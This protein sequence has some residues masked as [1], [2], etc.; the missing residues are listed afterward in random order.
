MM[1]RRLHSIQA[2]MPCIAFMFFI[3][4]PARAS[5]DLTIPKF[6]DETAS[7]GISAIYKGD[8]QYMVGGGVGAFDCNG[9]GYPDLAFAGGE[10][11]AS[12]FINHSQ[13]NGELKF[14]KSESGIE[15]D[16]VTGVY[17][18]DLDGDTI[19]DLIL[20]RVGEAVLMRGEGQCK[21]RS[22]NEEWHFD[23]GNAWW[24][25][26]S[27]MW[28]KG[29]T[30]PT[31][32]LGAYI[33]PKFEFEPW[34]HCGDNQLYRPLPAGNYAAPVAL[35]PSYCTLSM[36]F[37]DWNNS[38]VPSLRVSNDR[39]YY[40]GGQEQMWH[41]DSGQAPRLYT[42][43]E[44]WKFLKIWGMGIASTYLS[45]DIYPSYFLTSMSDNKLQ[46]LRN[47]KADPPK[48]DYKDVAFDFGAVAYRPYAGDDLRPSTGW[49]SEFGD[50]NN[51]GL[52]DLF[53][54]KGNVDRMPDFAEKDP[55]NLMLQK[56]DRKFQE[57]G[58]K[59]GIL[60]FSPARGG[61]LVDLNLDGKLDLVVTHRR[62]NAKVWRNISQ[63][64][65]HYIALR[66]IGADGNRDGIGAKIEIRADGRIQ[67]REIAS[68]GGH[69][70]G[71]NGFW[72]FGL[73]DATEA[74]VRIIW[75]DGATSEWRTLSAD[76]FYR[77]GR[78]GSAVEFKP[79]DRAN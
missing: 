70:G 57:V 5:D 71:Q 37:T 11:L 10:G 15:F 24:T 61:A 29:N 69:A 17:P 41:L 60:N 13:R 34:G 63:S 16:K 68:G 42:E 79:A 21:F 22:A 75:P 45:G 51:D 36:L 54:A 72:H 58:D 31:L 25:S 49:H 59:A 23:G 14:E 19:M 3:I 65:S 18:L 47:P 44:G 26:F 35:T 8:W 43:S 9:D 78:D 73:K 33:N 39:E 32:A 74:E 40:E 1:Q 64:D 48:P 6:Q 67:K 46:I 38:G 52:A 76:R 20:L 4:V 62:E 50:V 27:A 28:E 12:L 7:A 55:D 2:L 30:W 53:V 77:I 66:L 56:P